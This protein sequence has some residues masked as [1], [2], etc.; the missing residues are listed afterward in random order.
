MVCH[1]ELKI[2]SVSA[3]IKAYLPFGTVSFYGYLKI[4]LAS[5]KDMEIHRTGQ[6]YFFILYT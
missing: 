1:F 4:V 2:L 3:H 5:C 6:D